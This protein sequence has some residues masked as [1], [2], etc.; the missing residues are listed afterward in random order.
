MIV[1]LFAL[2][3]IAVPATLFAQEVHVSPGG[4]D[5]AAGTAAAPFRTIARARD[6]LRKHPEPHHAVLHAGTYYLGDTLVFTAED[7]GAYD[8]APGE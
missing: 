3:L 8:A 1:K 4:D 6:E 7:H 2:F 5:S